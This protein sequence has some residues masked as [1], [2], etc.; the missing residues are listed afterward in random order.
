MGASASAVI[1]EAVKNAGIGQ[2]TLDETSIE[3]EHE[4]HGHPGEGGE[5]GGPSDREGQGGDRRV[6]GVPAAS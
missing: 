6:A 1:L 4:V 2:R 3:G 5:G